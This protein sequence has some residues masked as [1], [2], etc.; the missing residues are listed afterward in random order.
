[1]SANLLWRMERCGNAYDAS[2]GMIGIAQLEPDVA[3]RYGKSVANS[4]LREDEI[5]CCIRGCDRWLL[6]RRRGN[7]GD[8]ALF[9]PEHRISVSSSPSFIY[10]QPRRNFIIAEDLLEE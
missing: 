10:E 4:F 2:T 5:H 9:C 1:M 6:R 7:L 3:T 8:K